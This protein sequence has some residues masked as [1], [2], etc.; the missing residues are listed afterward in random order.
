MPIDMI[1]TPAQKAASFTPSQEQR[2]K[3]TST[4]F[5]AVFV[6]QMLNLM[7]PESQEEIFSGGAAE[8][9]YKMFLNEYIS[10]DIAESG[11]VGLSDSIYNQ[12]LKYQ[13]A[14]Q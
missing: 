6:N 2:A 11:S 5:E 14:S 10:Q 1:Q 13:E 9:Q 4:D 12:L 8:K 3:K 7:E